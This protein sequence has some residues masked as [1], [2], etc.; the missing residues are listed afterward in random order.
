MSMKEL[1]ME[2]AFIDANNTEEISLKSSYLDFHLN[3]AQWEKVDLHSCHENH[4]C[5]ILNFR[6]VHLC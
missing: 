1:P 3:E 2:P 5:T 6:M 4:G